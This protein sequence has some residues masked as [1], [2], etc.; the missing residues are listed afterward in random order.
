[1]LDEPC[2]HE[3]G[4]GDE[5][6]AFERGVESFVV[7]GETSESRCPGEAPFDDPSAR[8]E[9]EAA[10]GQ[11]VLDHFEPYAVLLCGLGGI[12]SGIALVDIGQLDRS[13]GNLLNLFG[14]RCD[15]VAI[16][17]IGWR[18]GQGQKVAQRVDRDMHLGALAP[19]GPS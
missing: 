15:L 17:L 16:A 2:C 4:E 1:M 10:F 9:D 12:G 8:Q 3:D 7:S 18:Y 14:Q 6:E 11:W 13:A 19:L 5:V